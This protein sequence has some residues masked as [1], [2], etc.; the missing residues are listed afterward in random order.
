MERFWIGV[1]NRL[2]LW[3]GLVMGFWHRVYIGFRGL[4]LGIGF[5]VRG[6]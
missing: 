5:M 4:G 2:G 1:R 6:L 3:R